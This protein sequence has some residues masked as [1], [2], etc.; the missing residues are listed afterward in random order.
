[1]SKIYIADRYKYTVD[2]ISGIRYMQATP[3]CI[4]LLD[5][6]HDAAINN[7]AF[8]P[9]RMW[10]KSEFKAYEWLA[11]EAEGK[12]DNLQEECDRALAKLQAVRNIQARFSLLKESAQGL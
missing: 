9:A 12:E 4:V 2:E 3:D 10:F 5:G 8:V 11:K 1:M 7:L 6:K